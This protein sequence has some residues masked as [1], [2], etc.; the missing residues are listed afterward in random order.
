MSGDADLARV[1]DLFAD[2][3]RSRILLSLLDG[4]ELA[5]G[6]LADEAGVSRSTASAHLSRLVDGGLLVVRSQGRNRWFRLAGPH[7]G[8]LVERLAAFAPREESRSLRSAT[9]AERLRTA[10][11]C[12]D[13]F[14]GRLGVAIMG[15]L[16]EHGY[17]VGG[18]G[19]FHGGDAHGN[20]GHAGGDRPASAGHELDYRLTA[21]GREFLHRMDI[22]IPE[23]SRRP[24]IR[25][26]IDWTETRHHL[27]GAAGSAVRDRFLRA[28]WAERLPLY[29]AIRV[30]PSGSDALEEW[31]GIDW[32]AVST[33][34]PPRY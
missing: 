8:E 2:R 15:S 5:A 4:R 26:C 30:T 29:R 1:G 28:G 17:V 25:Y 31:F 6:V 20:A 22:R 19:L 12:Y 13:H 10:R 27:A 14:A 9:R 16:L 3:T 33:T 24:E 21:P 7:V 34:A 23:G 32:A 18:D 11:T